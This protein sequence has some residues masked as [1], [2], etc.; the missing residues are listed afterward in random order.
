MFVRDGCVCTSGPWGLAEPAPCDG[1][2]TSAP[3]GQGQ[4]RGKG[5]RAQDDTG[6][7]DGGLVG[8]V[9]EVGGAHSQHP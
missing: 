7:W 3:G 9:L 2:Q 8:G 5:G 1:Q 4:S 6:E